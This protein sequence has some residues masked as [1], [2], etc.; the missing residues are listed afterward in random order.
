VLRAICR[1]FHSAPTLSEVLHASVVWVRAA[2]GCEDAPVYI[3]LPNAAGNLRLAISDG[4]PADLGRRRSARRRLVFETGKPFHL[5]LGTAGLVLS[6]CPLLAGE[7]STGVVEV[8]APAHVINEREALLHAVFERIAV[9]V[10]DCQRREDL[11]RQLNAVVRP[12]RLMESLLSS[13]SPPAAVKAM[14]GM[15]F[16]RFEVPVA[17]WYGDET[18]PHLRL[19]AVRGLGTRRARELR[20][21]LRMMPPWDP[22]SEGDRTELKTQFGRTTGQSTVRS[23][24]AGRGLLLVAGS[25]GWMDT[26]LRIMEEV[27]TDVLRHLATVK[28]AAKRSEDLD[29]G[30]AMTAHEIRRPL[31]GAKA[32]IEQVLLSEDSGP[33]REMLQRTRG[34]LLEL[35]HI[36]DT[37]IRWSAGG[38]SIRR[39][40][41]RLAPIVQEAVDACPVQEGGR[42]VI[43]SVPPNVRVRADRR[44]LRLAIANVVRN[45]L[46]YSPKETPVR[47]TVR[48]RGGVATV[49][50]R[51]Q[52]PGVPPEDEIRIFDPFVTGGV[53]RRGRD[54]NGLGLFIARRV[55]EA[56]DGAIGIQSTGR[57]ATFRI[58][59]PAELERKPA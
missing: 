22:S 37:L 24:S 43:V 17:G 42:R 20:H 12:V 50:V 15:A 34:E 31:L 23:I 36:A 40:P 3:S 58:R 57:G 19:I 28:R 56:H 54:A 38:G 14:V 1:A 59:L 55:V 16:D 33:N 5:G 11:R 32:A 9:A 10:F 52:G 35:A 41:V 25:A 53:G 18:Q 29:L 13:G 4:E 39:R 47:V 6:M 7:E 26:D 49:T 45:A 2:A 44:H 8:V 21:Y 46:A 27:L 48:S 30:I 51:D